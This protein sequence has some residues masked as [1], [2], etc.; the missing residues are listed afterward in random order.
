MLVLYV[1]YDY[2]TSKFIFGP[3][4]DP[5]IVSTISLMTIREIEH[6]AE[7]SKLIMV[8]QPSQLLPL[9]QLQ[10]AQV[11]MDMCCWETCKHSNF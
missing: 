11:S 1:L 5:S 9:L 10:K 6:Y 8:E 4:V 7:S 2:E 3:T